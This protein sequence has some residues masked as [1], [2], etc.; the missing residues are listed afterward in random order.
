MYRKQLLNIKLLC[1]DVARSVLHPKRARNMCHRR[2][3]GALAFSQFLEPMHHLLCPGSHTREA[4]GK[5]AL[6]F[7]LGIWHRHEDLATGSVICMLRIPCRLEVNATERAC[8][9]EHSCMALL[10][11]GSGWWRLLSVAGAP[12]SSNRVAAAQARSEP[13]D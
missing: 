2:C 7:P 4:R 12:K 10:C 13:S 6:P 3:S 5:L 11:F 9:G 8:T 1:T